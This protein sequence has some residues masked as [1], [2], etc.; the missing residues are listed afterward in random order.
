VAKTRD[1]VEGQRHPARV[2]KRWRW[3]DMFVW[4][5]TVFAA[6]FVALMM[7]VTVHESL[8]L[9]SEK[10]DQNA[11]DKAPYCAA[12][13]T[14]TENC[15]L[16]TTAAVSEIYATASDDGDPVTYTTGGALK[17]SVGNDQKIELS[18]AEDLTKEVHLGD[19]LPVLVWHDEIMRF[20]VVGKTHNSDMNPHYLVATGLVAVPVCLPITVASGRPLLRRL[21]RARI[22]GNFRNRIPDWT[23]VTLVVATPIAALLQV[24]Y[25]VSIFGLA[26]VFVL[27]GSAVWPFI[28]WV[29]RQR[30]DRAL[31]Y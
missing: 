7:L 30:Y 26:G 15:I 21:L 28:P 14:V 29:A 6:L 23:M 16:R 5:G 13:E 2:T 1:V 22:K 20:T 12:G 19:R 4:L 24:G 18:N 17:P 31:D 27:L 8:K 11:Y 25:V 9:M 3:T 10:H